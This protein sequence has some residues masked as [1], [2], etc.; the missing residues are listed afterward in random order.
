VYAASF[1]F[2]HVVVASAQALGVFEYPRHHV[3][4][5]RLYLLCRVVRPSKA[6]VALVVRASDTNVVEVSAPPDL[7]FG[8]P[9]GA[10]GPAALRATQYPARELTLPG[11]GSG[12][13]SVVLDV[14]SCSVYPLAEHCL[15]A[16]ANT[17]STGDLMSQK[18]ANGGLGL[19]TVLTSA[20]FLG[21]ILALVVYLSVSRTDRIETTERP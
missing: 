15:I 2:D 12:G 18:H 4:Y 16:E 1:L 6:T 5:S 8:E 11:S 3:P 9:A 19:G 7:G 20:H 13:P 17:T 21:T 14:L 10:H